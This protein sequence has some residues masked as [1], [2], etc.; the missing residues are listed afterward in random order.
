MH[1]DAE[2][3]AKIDEC[4]FNCKQLDSLVLIRQEFMVGLKEAKEMSYSRYI[5]LLETNPNAFDCDHQ[6]CYQGVGE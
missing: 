2:K 1:Q 4:I 3:W 5:Y 6:N